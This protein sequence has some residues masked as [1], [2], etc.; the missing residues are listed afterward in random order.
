M[1]VEYRIGWAFQGCTDWAAWHDEDASCAEVQEALEGAA[2][3]PE[4]LA[5]AI[6]ASGFGWYVETREVN[7]EGDPEAQE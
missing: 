4:G 3:L 7:E 1:A 2:T 5:E 6:E